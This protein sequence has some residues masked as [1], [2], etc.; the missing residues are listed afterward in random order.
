MP[1]VTIEVASPRQAHAEMNRLYQEHVKPHTHKGARCRITFETVNPVYRHELRKLF[2]GPMLR[3]FALQVRTLNLETGN[4]ER[5]AVAAWK[6]LLKDLFCP[7]RFDEASGE[8]QPRS[9]EALSDDDFAEFVL[10]C[11][12]FGCLDLDVVFTELPTREEPAW[13]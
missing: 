7:P 6:I 8:E 12:A 11:H 1:T 4:Y 13:Q 9:T 10:Q 2:H 5:W 3:D